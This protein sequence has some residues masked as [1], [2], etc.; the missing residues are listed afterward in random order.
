MISAITI[1]LIFIFSFI[2]LIHFYWAFGGKWG[3]NNVVPTQT[4]N[5]T[6]VLNPSVQSTLVVAIGLLAF[7]L[8]TLFASGLT[9]IALPT[10]ISNMG[11][12]MIVVVFSL[13]AIG[14]FKY[15]GF[16][17]KIK[18]TTFGIN[19]TKYFSPLCLVI[20]ILTLSLAL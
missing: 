12:W 18:Q 1:I 20:A 11:R 17:K 5:R 13:R 9:V 7:G 14:D 8:F 16:F 6:K 3:S 2:S 15:V 4:D 19:D 10:W